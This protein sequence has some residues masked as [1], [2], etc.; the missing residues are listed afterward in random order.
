MAIRTIL[1]DDHRLFR[2]GL[3]SLLKTNEGIDVIGEAANGR[4]GVELTRKL[5]PQL[6]IVDPSMPDLNGID[7]A[8]KIKHDLPRIKIIAL[9][10]HSDRRFV[11]S[12]LAAGTSGYLL[13]TCDESETP[14]RHH[15]RHVRKNLPHPRRVRHGRRRTDP[16]APRRRR[17]YHRFPFR[18]RA[19]NPPAPLR[20]QEHK[21]I[22]T[23]LNVSAR[24][25]DSHRQH[26]MAKL[27]IY[28]VAELTKYAVK[29]GL[30]PL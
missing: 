4:E 15:R 29:C 3:R 10:M 1:I 26:I 13:K 8:A 2:L 12:M 5:L 9:S 17:R 16:S 25:I 14:P 23:H 28:T 7:A 22:G 6:V 21:E 24:T 30:T 19:R 20:G 18:S 27:D 11:S